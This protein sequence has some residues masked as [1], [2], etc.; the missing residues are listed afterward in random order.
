MSDAGQSPT[1]DTGEIR[2]EQFQPLLNEPLQVVG[3]NDVIRKMEL[4]SVNELSHRHPFRRTPGFSMVL[5][6]SGAETWQQDMCRVSHPA[7]GSFDFL[8]TP[9]HPMNAGRDGV[10]ACYQI[11]VN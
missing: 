3:Q 9:I 6:E 7:L 10:G 11:I 4:V 5:W 2:A 1:E 8:M